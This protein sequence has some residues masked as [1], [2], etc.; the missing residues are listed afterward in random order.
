MLSKIALLASAA[1]AVAHG[2]TELHGSGTTNPSKFF[3]EAM[4][5]LEVTIVIIIINTLPPL[6]SLP[7]SSHRRHHY[8]HH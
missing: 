6:L 4:D 7:S 8:D 3:W 5:M 1:V 2:A